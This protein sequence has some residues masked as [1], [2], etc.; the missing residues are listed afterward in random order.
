MHTAQAVEIHTRDLRGKVNELKA[1]D[2]ILL[3]GTVYT[4]RDAAHKRLMALIDS[5][6]P[7]PFPLTDAIIYYCGST[8]APEG[9]PIGSCGPTTSERM[10][11]FTPRLYAMGLLATIGKGERSKAV[12]EAI[13]RYQG[14]YLCAVGGAG[15]LAAKCVTAAQV[16]AFPELGCEAVKQLTIER[17]PLLVAL[18]SHGGSIFSQS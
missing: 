12:A 9:R 11:P 13:V 16:I 4:A 5:G 10:D 2:R 17:F 15:A 6:Q 1:G 8:P 3:S 14:L 7:L 18:N